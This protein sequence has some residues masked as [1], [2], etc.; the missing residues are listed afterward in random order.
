MK[1]QPMLLLLLQQLLIVT[2]ARLLQKIRREEA[3]TKH[4]N[5]FLKRM[6][7]LDTLL[8]NYSSKRNLL[9]E[10]PDK[11]ESSESLSFDAKLFSCRYIDGCFECLNELINEEKVLYLSANIPCNDLLASLHDNDLCSKVTIL[12]TEN[13]VC[14]ILKSIPDEDED[15]FDD[16][17]EDY[18]DDDNDNLVDC[19]SLTSCYWDGMHKG[20]LGDGTCHEHSDGGCYNH[21]ICNYDDGDCCEDTCEKK[22]HYNKCGS[23]GGYFCRDPNSTNTEFYPDTNESTETDDW[24]D[25]DVFDDDWKSN[26]LLATDWLIKCPKGTT[27]Y[28][29]SMYDSYGGEEGWGNTEIKIFPK[30]A[31]KKEEVIYLGGLNYGS[32]GTVPLCLSSK[33]PMCYE[34]E[35]FGGNWAKEATWEIKPL[36]ESPFLASGG[37]PMVC[38]FP[39]NGISCE[40]TCKGVPDAKNVAIDKSYESFSDL[41]TCRNSECVLEKTFCDKDTSCKDCLVE[42]VPVFCYT[43]DIFKKLASC[44]TDNCVKKSEKKAT[45]KEQEQKDT[46][47]FRQCTSSDVIDGL[48]STEQYTQCAGIEQDEMK[49]LF[50]K[51]LYEDSFGAL[52]AFENCAHEWSNDE[53][54]GGKTALECMGILANAI[55]DPSNNGSY[56]LD[57]VTTKAV[58]KLAEKIYNDADNFCECSS[59]SSSKCPP[60]EAFK[61]YK[62]LLYESLNACQS[63]DAIDCAAWDLFYDTCKI[64]FEKKFGKSNIQFR[65]RHCNFISEDKCGLF[66]LSE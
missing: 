31:T 41:E 7:G 21:K 56:Q 18:E 34:V 14:D 58:S 46:G 19:E 4:G 6:R 23:N 8:S 61:N 27:K 30:G 39:V 51:S 37:A 1:Q 47:D 53:F 60:C 42:D 12:S 43:N 49:A 3:T 52:D 25:D 15:D 20:Y 57:D 59:K 40:N 36:V 28:R 63:L 48:Q 17:E 35:T 33:D 32:S 65:S 62:T 5:H 2:P 55:D 45:K 66:I 64:N 54:H 9:N 38:E 10:D 22:K 26:E 29:L 24:L 44:V 16:D 50:S 13:L 11:E